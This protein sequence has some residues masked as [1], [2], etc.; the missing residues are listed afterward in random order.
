MKLSRIWMLAAVAGVL[1]LAFGACG[2][3][4]DAASGDDA[5]AYCEIA[6]ELDEQ[7]DFPSAEQLEGLRDAAPEEIS[8]EVDLVV[9]AFLQGIEDGDPG[10]AFADPEVEE[11][12]GPIETF[13]E[14]TCGLEGDEADDE[15]EQDASVTELDPD[16]AQVAVSATD[17]AFEF[18]APTAGPTSFTMTNDGDET[19]VM[20]LAKVAEGSSVEEVLEA[21]DT[22]GL[23]DVE[24]V[25]DSATP[26]DEAVLTADLTPGD[27]VMVCFLPDADGTPHYELGMVSDF[28]I[29]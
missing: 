15:P 27:W 20:L 10:A 5:A 26:G 25:S 13:E 3:D 16:A 6:A 2:D 4:D 21:E 14:E 22:E 29:T 19:H 8:D 1:S 18:G 24:L 17:Y 28:T 9:E 7:E 11:A 23:T 12:F